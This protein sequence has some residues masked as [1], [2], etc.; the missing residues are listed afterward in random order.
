ME[1]LHDEGT[2]VS[3]TPASGT[4]YSISSGSYH[5]TI[6]SIGASI[7]SLTFEGRDLVVPF[8]ADAVRPNFRGAT[9]APWPNRVIDG[10]YSFVGADQQ[11]AHTEPERGHALHG[12]VAWLDFAPVESGDDHVVLSAVVVPQVG[13]PHRVR[14][15]VRFALDAA[16]LT[17]TITATNIGSTAAPYGCSAHPYLVAG[18]G[19]VDDWVLTLPASEVMLV[20]EDR[21]IPTGQAS[22]AD[23]LGGALDFRTA[24][25]IGTTFI[26]HAFTNLPFPD[27][28]TADARTTVT[29][30]AA[31]GTGVSLSWDATCPWVQVH[32]ADR[33][34]PESNRVGL[35]V[36]PMTC[37][38]D[39]FNSGDSV[40]TLEPGDTHAAS[41]TIAAISALSA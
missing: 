36:E 41:W 19:L 40:V 8:E 29:V 7:R 18:P 3:G 24:R 6:A 23:A 38:P 17:Q 20:T 11:L 26:D 22:V 39:A 21:L 9:L 5:A 25:T 1:P 34:E 15:D 10:R 32:T 12:L 31:G 13:Y 37:P 35:A 27:P 28:E 14:V 30:T 4:Q 33:P 16:G 2:P